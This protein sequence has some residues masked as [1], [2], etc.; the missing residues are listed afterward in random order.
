MDLPLS[1]LNVHQGEQNDIQAPELGPICPYCPDSV[2]VQLAAEFKPAFGR[3]WCPLV[4]FAAK[5]RLMLL[6][7]ATLQPLPLL[8]RV[9][10]QVG[11]GNP[12]SEGLFR[13]SPGR[14][15]DQARRRRGSMA[16]AMLRA[17]LMST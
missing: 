6:Q 16:C 5:S 15:L 1:V 3:S 13:G 7:V 11:P 4:V 17:A 10:M 8:N 14:C 12:H 2:V 9:R